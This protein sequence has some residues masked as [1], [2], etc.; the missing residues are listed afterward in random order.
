MSF[1]STCSLFCSSVSPVIIS[2][3]SQSNFILD[4]PLVFVQASDS[5]DDERMIM[6]F[7]PRIDDDDELLVAHIEL[8]H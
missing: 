5:T 4:F 3:I 8:T 7:S 1:E 2:I 6:S